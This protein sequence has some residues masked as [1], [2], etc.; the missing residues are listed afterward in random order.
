MNYYKYW[1]I[2]HF[3]LDID[4]IG[5]IKRHTRVIKPPSYEEL[6]LNIKNDQYIKNNLILNSQFKVHD[7]FYLREYQ[8]EQTNIAVE[9]G[10]WQIYFSYF[11]KDTLYDYTFI[12]DT[13][14]SFINPEHIQI[15]W[16]EKEL[17]YY[18]NILDS[19]SQA[20][21][22]SHIGQDGCYSTAGQVILIA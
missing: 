11:V 16:I 22:T 13:K 8:Y 14:E 21:L 15:Y 9:N 19:D 5:L 17:I 4:V 7:N 2:N 18:E 12:L 20:Q 6:K 3:E 10:I 1:L